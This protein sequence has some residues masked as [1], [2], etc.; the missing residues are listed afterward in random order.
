MENT[1]PRVT[2]LGLNYAPEPTGIA[3]YTV[4]LAR[5]LNDRGFDV[6]VLTGYPH[7]PAWKIHRGY[8]G[9]SK[10]ELIDGVSV[11]RLRH[12][13]PDGTGALGRIQLE[14]SFGGRLITSRWK[15]PDVVV[16]VTPALLSTA[17]ALTR[18]RLGGRRR[19]AVGVWVQDLYGLGVVETG[20]LGGTAARLTALI[21]SRAL[22]AADG[23][24]VIHSRFKNHVVQQL[25]VDAARVRVVRNWTHHSPAIVDNIGATRERLGW[26]DEETIVLHAGNMGAKQGLGSVVAAARMAQARAEKVRF[27]LMGDGNQRRAL[28]EAASDCRNITF[29][30][31]L[32][33]EEFEAAL[34]CADILLLNELPSL[35]EM[36]VPSKLTSYFASGTAVIAATDEKSVTAAE[37][38]E[39]GAGLRVEPGSPDALLA[40]VLQLSGDPAYARKLSAA[41]RRF[42]KQELSAESALEKFERWIIGLHDNRI[43]DD[44]EG[45]E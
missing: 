27:V 35:S 14:T 11:R 13:V 22:R 42:Q 33:L 40:G 23:V 36:A 20:A 19:P 18:A 17:A 41:G 15:R 5:G 34:Q 32:P 3:P 16:C 43:N 1:K 6:E 8:G 10:R 44:E 39:S 38:A 37:I 2:I 45:R 21:E 7:Y 25:G 29:I 12:M 26:Q 30:D 9:W 31:P 24:A 4:G 28:E